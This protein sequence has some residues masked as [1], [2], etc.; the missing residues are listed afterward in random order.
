MTV[1][2]CNESDSRV[3]VTGRALSIVAVSWRD[4]AH[5]LAGGAEV[6]LDRVL[7]GLHER[8][9]QVTLVCGGPLSEHPYETVD[10]GG[11]YSQYLRAPAICT[12]RFRD[13]DIV[14]DVQNG[15]PYFSP[16]WRRRPSVCVVHHV[17][18]DQWAARFPAPIAAFCRAVERRVMPFAYRNRRFLAI[19]RSTAHS[20]AAIGVPSESITVVESGV[21]SPPAAS[22][23]RSGEPLILS[24][25]R[26]VP[27]K[28]IDLLLEAWSVAQARV[29][30]RLVVAGGGPLLHDLRL[31][32]RSIPRVDVLGRV[33]EVEKAD[34]LARAWVVVSTA[35]HEG[36]GMSVLE[37]AAF[38]TPGLAID[39]P[40]IRDALVDGV[41]G[42]L[43]YPRDDM[44]IPE[45]LAQA[46]EALLEDQS[47]REAFGVAARRRALDLSWSRCVDRWEAELIDASS[48]DRIGSPGGKAECAFDPGETLEPD[49]RSTSLGATFRAAPTPREERR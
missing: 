23:K 1:D 34:L 46:M 7:H 18:T 33:D 32:A 49:G 38:G 24:L 47:Q 21:D 10:S 2:T 8:G 4:L 3:H 25:N 16:L 27:H 30:G 12:R 22:A 48:R 26:L 5:P 39:A 35:H 17:H 28:R 19:S 42:R 6:L 45:T 31:Q 37:G 15:M 44:Q 29:P 11:T 40:G 41:T 20:L 14:I 13:A 9:H 43:V 36:W